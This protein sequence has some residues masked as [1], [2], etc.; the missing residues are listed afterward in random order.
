MPALNDKRPPSKGGAGAR[1]WIVEMSIG[2]RYLP[3]LRR[4]VVLNQMHGS[5]LFVKTIERSF[6]WDWYYLLLLSYFF[7][8]G[9][10]G[11]ITAAIG[12]TAQPAVWD[13]Y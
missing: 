4:P 6:L 12:V 5:V 11:G 1:R 8:V 3:E 7:S 13:W 9:C 2:R 10:L